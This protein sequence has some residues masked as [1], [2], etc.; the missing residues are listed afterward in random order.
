MFTASLVASALAATAAT[1]DGSV[2]KL[3]FGNVRGV[4][5]SKHREFLGIPYATAERFAAP[6]PWAEPYPAS[7]LDATTLTERCWQPGCTAQ[8][9]SE[10]CLRLN[11]FAP[12]SS[13]AGAAVMLWIHGGALDTGSAMTPL[14]NGTNLVA[15][16]D[17]VVVAMNYRLNVFG[18]SAVPQADGSVLANHGYR[19]QREGM[20]WVRKNIGAFGGDAKRV[21]I[22]GESAGGQ[23]VLAH[24]LSPGSA[25]LFDGAISESGDVTLVQSSLTE[26]LSAFTEMGSAVGCTSKGTS[27][28]VACMQA[29]D[30]AKL[31]DAYSS[32]APSPTPAVV[33]GDIY[34]ATPLELATSGRFNRVPLIMGSNADEGNLF[35]M[36]PAYQ[37]A[38]AADIACAFN[39]T[40]VPAKAAKMLDMYTPTDAPGIDNRKQISD[41]F[42]D[43]L[44][45]CVDRELARGFT[46]NGVA[47]W[48]YKFK[49]APV[50]STIPGT[51][52]AYHSSEIPVAWDLVAEISTALGHNCSATKEE[53]SLG[54]RMAEL[55]ASFATNLQADPA[56]QPYSLPEEPSLSIDLATIHNLDHDEG[57]RRT[58][59]DLIDAVVP[60]DGNVPQEVVNGLMSGL[61]SCQASQRIFV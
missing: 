54:H 4:V 17:V 2:V 36:N 32:L 59:C 14:Y 47:P 7:G 20:R 33:D 31:V 60:K 53:I 18:F 39:L 12:M 37:P 38:S 10:S 8:T 19:D 11:V 1:D 29:V 9:C 34:P 5:L 50:C 26:K 57:Y 23:S 61:Q 13:K 28:L 48:I 55:W 42:S 21:T 35:F 49:R 51:P 45:H 52:G 46:K 30:A 56:W 41:V 22:F 15:K 3:P 16:H 44:Y 40:F 27:D 25:G 6:E 58:Q 43:L 24:V